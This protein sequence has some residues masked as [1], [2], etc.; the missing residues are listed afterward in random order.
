M[1]TFFMISWS[2][3][4]LKGGMPERMMY[5]ITP[6]DQISHFWLYFL[7]RTSGAM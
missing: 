3:E 4:P 5:M 1:R 7:L 6:H 2:L